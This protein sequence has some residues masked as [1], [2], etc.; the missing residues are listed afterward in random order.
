ME[1]ETRNVIV[2]GAGIAGLTCAYRLKQAGC[3]VT[4]VE[5]TD[6]V[7]GVMRSR[8]EH[9]FL[10]EQGP[11]SFQNTPEILDL[12]HE[13][14]LDHELVTAEARLP[15]YI[16]YRGTLHRAPMAPAALLSTRLLTPAGKLKIIRELWTKS[17]S[18]SRDESLSDFVIRHFGTEVLRNF[19]APLVS[20]IYA[21]DPSRL[22]ARS[23]FPYLIDLE[24]EYGSL[25][26]GLV[27]SARRSPKPRRPRQLCSF[28]QGLQRLP[29]RLA[30]RIGADNVMLR[31]QVQNLRAISR[32]GRN[33]F[34]MT[35]S[36]A[37]GARE[38]AGSAVV[39]A[40]PA[41]EAAVLLQSFSTGCATELASIEYPPL[42]VLCLAYRKSD[43]PHPLD[44]FG[45]L[46]PRGEGVRFLGCIWSSTLFSGRAQADAALLTIF[47]GGATDTGIASLSDGQVV[48]AALQDLRTTL[49]ITAAPRIMSVHRYQRAIPQPTLGYEARLQRID[50]ELGKIPGIYL[51][52]NYLRGVSIPDSVKQASEV[53][54]RIRWQ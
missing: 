4:V 22:S 40:T 19:V 26:K 39:I 20:G 35:V 8:I 24:R 10:C 17:G 15:R 27:F 41:Y 52:G 49:K 36:T 2:I 16:F 54:N 12:V 9:D 23:A 3:P 30:E 18:D 28:Q 5:S 50:Q 32:G 38:L 37:D 42:A 45:F 21:G 43:V 33:A 31:R 25:I 46:V 1:T 11:N 29:L 44:G 47:A 48:D 13:L 53:A 34:T 51:A 6:C 7:G 14:G